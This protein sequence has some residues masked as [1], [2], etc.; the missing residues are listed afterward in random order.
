MEKCLFCIEQIRFGG[1][2]YFEEN[3][4]IFCSKADDG[5]GFLF[6]TCYNCWKCCAYI[7][8]TLFYIKAYLLFKFFL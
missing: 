6:L 2:V 1:N 4:D 3:G 5:K 7:I 8:S